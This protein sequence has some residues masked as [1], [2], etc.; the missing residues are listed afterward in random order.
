MKKK[1]TVP[2][3]RTYVYIYVYMYICIYD[4]EALVYTVVFY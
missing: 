3:R 1:P 4:F 2:D